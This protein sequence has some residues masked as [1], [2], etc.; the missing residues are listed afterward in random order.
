MRSNDHT[1]FKFRAECAADAQVIR[2]VL[3]PSL[4]HWQETRDT[5]E[6]DGG[7]HALPDVTVEFSILAGGPALDEIWWLV[8]CV[9]NCHVAAESIELIEN[10]TGERKTRRR[11][12][13][14]ARMPSRELLR[15]AVA[16]VKR[17]QEVLRL[18]LE[19][20]QQLYQTCETAARLGDK[21]QPVNPQ[22]PSPGWVV[23]VELEGTGHTAMRRISAP[24]GCKQ[25][26]RLE[27]SLVNGRMFTIGN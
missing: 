14:P 13:A 6:H 11:F 4:L 12:E 1:T 21:W 9:C 19:R 17:R 2:A 23:L 25:W 10:Y 16:A 24:L 15:Q 20:V 18:E 8:D 5:L 26:Q 7:L 22:I 27:K 3:L